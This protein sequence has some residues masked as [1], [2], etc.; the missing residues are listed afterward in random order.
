MDVLSV[1]N[2]VRLT[3]LIDALNFDRISEEVIAGD[4]LIKQCQ[5]FGRYFQSSLPFCQQQDD[6]QT[7][8]KAMY[9]HHLLLNL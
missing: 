4:G 2:L 8:Q 9:A 5:W 7:K 3:V 1:P 6:I